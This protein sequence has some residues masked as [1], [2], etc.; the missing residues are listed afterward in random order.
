[1]ESTVGIGTTFSLHLKRIHAD[2]R[3]S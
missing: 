3:E 1:V 2:G